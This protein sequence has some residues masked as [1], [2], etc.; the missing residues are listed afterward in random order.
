MEGGGGGDTSVIDDDE[1][2]LDRGF[3]VN[4]FWGERERER[5][6]VSSLA[7]TPTNR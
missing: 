3:V 6:R 2:F 7:P 5:E 1:V 4:G